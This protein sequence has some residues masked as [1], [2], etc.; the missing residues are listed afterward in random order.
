MFQER[1]ECFGGS[2]TTSLTVAIRRAQVHVPIHS[3]RSPALP[4][5]SWGRSSSAG[6]TGAGLADSRYI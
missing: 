2:V 3:I 5:A 6:G 1:P 4:R